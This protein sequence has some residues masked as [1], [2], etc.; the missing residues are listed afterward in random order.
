M[1]SVRAISLLLLLMPLAIVAQDIHFSQFYMN[2]IY[3]NPALT[4]DFNGEWRFTGNQRTQWKS[5]SRPYNTIAI[6]AENKEEYVLPGMYH[7][8]NLFHDVAGDGNYR[9]IEFNLSTSYRRFLDMDSI[10]SITTGIQFGVNHR[11]IDFSKLNFDNQFNGYYYDPTLPT[12]EIFG[13]SKRTG[14]NFNVGAMYA[15]RPEYR[16][17]VVAGIGWFNI[18]QIKQ[19]LYSDDLIKRD[20]RLVFHAKG[21]YDLNFEWDL[22]PGIIM[23]FQGDYKEIVF[24]SNIRYVMIDKKGEYIAPYGGIWFRNRDAAYLVA[25]LYYNDWIAGISYDFNIS[26]LIPASNVR[27]GI[28][29]SV[30]YILHLFKPKDIQHRVCPDYL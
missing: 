1:K 6:S 12:M 24:G 19:S 29:F 23:Q 21:N 9:T 28:E 25:G 26:K 8:V 14:F 30:Q 4:G 3:L 10:H 16:K 15:Y 20:R 17:E 13:T 7:A 5:V 2:P 27:G 11:N 22:Q 18:P